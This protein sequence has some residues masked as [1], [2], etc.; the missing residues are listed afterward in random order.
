MLTFLAEIIFPII[1]VIFSCFLRVCEKL[2]S[3]VWKNFKPCEP[4]QRSYYQM[5]RSNRLVWGCDPQNCS[6]HCIS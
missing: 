2:L 4:I 1:F 5:L 6:A 3:I